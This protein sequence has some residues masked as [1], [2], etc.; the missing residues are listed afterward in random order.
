MSAGLFSITFV[1]GTSA[2]VGFSATIDDG[3]ATTFNQL[4]KGRHRNKDFQELYNDYGRDGFLVRT[5]HRTE[6][7]GEAN[8]IKQALINSGQYTLNKLKTMRGIEQDYAIVEL[9]KTP[10]GTFK[11]ASSAVFNAPVNCLRN[12]LIFRICYE[13][14]E[15]ISARDYCY[16]SLVFDDDETVIGT[17]WIDRG[18]GTV[19]RTCLVSELGGIGK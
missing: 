4:E 6:D 2:Y 9:F 7:E 1:H 15:V 14:D 3:V 12:E 17:R 19:R 5:L 16:F 11:S 18:F 10:W 8:R 13:P